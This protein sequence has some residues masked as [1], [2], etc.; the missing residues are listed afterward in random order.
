MI[1]KKVFPGLLL[2]LLMVTC[3]A[4]FVYYSSPFGDTRD[5]E[6]D[7]DDDGIPIIHAYSAERLAKVQHLHRTHPHGSMTT[8]GLSAM[9]IEQ[10]RVFQLLSANVSEQL[11]NEEREKTEE[12][13]EG[14]AGKVITEEEENWHDHMMLLFEGGM[15]LSELSVR[16]L[17][18]QLRLLGVE[19][20]AL[21][22]P[23]PAS[24]NAAR[25]PASYFT[26]QGLKNTDSKKKKTGSKYVLT[27]TTGHPYFSLQPILSSSSLSTLSFLSSALLKLV[28]SGGSDRK[29][30]DGIKAKHMRGLF[31]DDITLPLAIVERLSSLLLSRG[32]ALK[33]LTAEQ[34]PEEV[35][36]I[37][38]PA[39]YLQVV[40]SQGQSFLVTFTTGSPFFQIH[41][42]L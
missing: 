13:K 16:T 38:G 22:G 4:G 12:R 10:Q 26:V 39:A 32:V 9:Q 29:A 8:K 5:D 24:I 27:V 41:S 7:D 42:Y 11:L 33:H 40:S 21:Y 19:A 35:P 18:E 25:G 31:G 1:Q 36:L 34:V 3:V 23:L 2:L 20:V 30:L 28:E 15:S 17:V 37:R 6:D 14:D